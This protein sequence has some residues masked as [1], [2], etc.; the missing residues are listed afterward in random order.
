MDVF[1][2]FFSEVICVW[3]VVSVLVVWFICNL[4]LIV[5]LSYFKVSLMIMMSLG[6]DKWFIGKDVL[7][8]GMLE[9]KC[10]WF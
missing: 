3:V 1:K 6:G 8:D 5:Y 9:K 2:F 4:I 7:K 10:F